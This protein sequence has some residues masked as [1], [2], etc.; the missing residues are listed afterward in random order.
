MKKLLMFCVCVSMF[1]FPVISQAKDNAP[2]TATTPTAQTETKEPAQQVTQV[3][4]IVLDGTGDVTPE[5]HRRWLYEVK[6]VYRLP[7]YAYLKDNKGYI[8]ATQT[9]GGTNYNT[10]N[11]P[12]DVLEQIAKEANAQMVALMIIHDMSERLIHSWGPWDDEDMYV[13]VYTSADLYMYKQDGQQMK[14]SNVRD[15]STYDMGNQTH[16][17]EVIGKA[18]NRLAKSF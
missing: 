10:G 9:I 5:M 8:A 15:I 2:A 3:A 1:L 7:K 14:K 16:S 12:V 6:D 13:R 4:F 18:M 11:L 17:Y